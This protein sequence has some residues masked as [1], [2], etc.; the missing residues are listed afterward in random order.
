M[1]RMTREDYEMT[2][3]SR[4]VGGA[5]L[6]SRRQVH[7][8][9]TKRDCYWRKD[10]SKDRAEW[11]LRP[12]NKYSFSWASNIAAATADTPVCSDDATY[13]DSGGYKCAGWEGHTCPVE[14]AELRKKCIRACG[15]CPKVRRAHQRTLPL[16]PPQAGQAPQA[17]Q[18]P[19]STALVPPS[20]PSLGACHPRLPHP[21]HAAVLSSAPVLTDA[22]CMCA[23]PL[24]V[25]R[26]CPPAPSLCLPCT[27]LMD[28]A[29]T[30]YAWS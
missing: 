4:A 16:V 28:G 1:Y 19:C 17:T 3:A 6:P 7:T 10:A 11:A 8:A 12:G 20:P 21:P 30:T 14:K 9:L 22:H 27:R 15:L 13:T 18:H 2:S 25:R 23:T 5:L 26:C 29:L 24:P